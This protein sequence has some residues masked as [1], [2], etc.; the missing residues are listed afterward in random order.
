M[1][2]IKDWES[3]WKK[4]DSI[5]GGGQGNTYYAYEIGTHDTYAIKFL[6]SPKDK[7]RRERMFIEVSC[8]QIL[9]H[10]NIPKLIDD[11]KD[12]Y[13][14]ESH[15]LYFVSD[16]IPGGTL[17]DYVDTN[18]T[19][20]L[21][22]SLLFTAS[23]CEIVSY[24][25]SK[26]VYHRDLK[27]DNI[28]IK[29]GDLSQPYLIDFGLSF[30]NTLSSEKGDTPS[31][32]HIG[33]RFLS[34]PELRVSESNKRDPRSDVTMICGIFFF[35]LTGIHPTDLIDEKEAKPHR[36]E[37]A[38]SIIEGKAN[39]KLD[40]INHFFDIGF[41]Q[42]INNRWQSINAISL[43]INDIFNMKP[44]LTSTKDVNEKLE[45]FKR[46]MESRTDY[47]QLDQIH[48]MLS[49]CSNSINKAVEEVRRKLG[50]SKYGTTQTGYNL[51]VSKQVF[52]NQIGI[53]SFY[54]DEVLFF[55]KFSFYSNGS[56]FVLD[57]EEK[58]KRTELA[59]LQLH[60][61]IDWGNLQTKVVEYY[62]N[63]ITA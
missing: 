42:G 13:R 12:M 57:A 51:S 7:E 28:I 58:G 34:L 16:Y 54:S 25:H 10:E 22:Q 44:D 11:N 3:R 40:S 62:V 45:S 61:Q 60:E 49:E 56:E 1:A 39:F 27:P 6:K 18:G 31:W 29:D 48:T 21:E 35:C 47:Q 20:S 33:N 8:L 24:C 53:K 17:Q 55:P 41:N 37:K 52:H 23:I 19:L 50:Y 9:S 46:K 59:R 15:E 43:A 36:R 26:E 38:K 63:G 14:D 4:G 32:Q 2:M 30:N 5:G